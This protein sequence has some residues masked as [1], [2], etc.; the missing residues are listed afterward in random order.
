M[1]TI[2]KNKASV[3]KSVK[4]RPGDRENENKCPRINQKRLVLASQE[5]PAVQ[6]TLEKVKKSVLPYVKNPETPIAEIFPPRHKKKLYQNAEQSEFFDLYHQLR[7]DY[8][9]VFRESRLAIKFRDRE[10][11][12]RPEIDPVVCRIVMRRNCHEAI[13][14]IRRFF[15]T[16]HSLNLPFDTIFRFP[17]FPFFHPLSAEF[18]EVVKAGNATNL[19]YMISEISPYLVFEFDELKQTALHWAVKKNHLTCVRI[20]IESKA[21]V[22]SLDILG[23]PPIYY[24][25]EARNFAMVKILFGNSASVWSCANSNYIDLAQGNKQIIGCIKIFRLLEIFLILRKY[26]DSKGA[27][28]LFLK[29]PVFTA[30]ECSF[31]AD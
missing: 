21:L 18:F 13:F 6:S 27:K 31:T 11:A 3:E 22:D 26:R 9:N 14:R 19:L 1:P 24:A 8:Q 29:S 17:H 15:K 2:R 25:I 16:Y 4:V 12:L 5:R 28:L 7:K 30:I 23:H 20:L 10:T